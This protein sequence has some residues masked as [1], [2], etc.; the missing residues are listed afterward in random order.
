MIG[1]RQRLCSV[2]KAP[3][4][5]A[6]S[7]LQLLPRHLH[8]ASG[9]DKKPF[10]CRNA[11]RSS[12]SEDTKPKRFRLIPEYSSEMDHIGSICSTSPTKIACLARLKEG[13]ASSGRYPPRFI[14][15]QQID[16]IT[17]AAH[18]TPPLSAQTTVFRQ[19]NGKSK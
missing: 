18:P 9:R 19:K 10:S 8:D 15:N 5:P 2:K 13:I 3:L 11:Y 14:H 16:R 12:D 6:T 17:E 1:S 4:S 7:K